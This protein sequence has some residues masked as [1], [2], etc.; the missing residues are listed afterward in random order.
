MTDQRVPAVRA[1][2]VPPGFAVVAGLGAIMLA[3]TVR[4][5]QTYD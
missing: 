3:L 4:M 1:G 5:I 2:E